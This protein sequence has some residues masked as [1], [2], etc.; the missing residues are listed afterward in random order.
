MASQQV[1]KAEIGIIGGTGV[2]GFDG[3][4]NKVELDN[5]DTPF[6]QTSS[7]VIIGTYAGENVAFIARHDVHH[8]FTPS[9]VPYRANIY[10][11]KTLGVKYLYVLLVFVFV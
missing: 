10:A 4:E 6:G 8:R 3:L 11:L 2:Y 1:H 9:E 5:I 7:K